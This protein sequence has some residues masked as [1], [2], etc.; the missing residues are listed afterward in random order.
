MDIYHAKQCPS[1]CRACGDLTTGLS[2]LCDACW[3]RFEARH[4]ILDR[5]AGKS[6]D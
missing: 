6:A 1:Y 4:L 3:C 5:D 2:R